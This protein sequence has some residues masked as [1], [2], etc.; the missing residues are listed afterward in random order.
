MHGVM[1]GLQRPGPVATILTKQP[2]PA[3][4]ERRAVMFFPQKRPPPLVRRRLLEYHELLGFA[5]F[6]PK[7][8]PV[9]RQQAAVDD[10]RPGRYLLGLFRLPGKAGPAQSSARASIGLISGE[11]D[12]RASPH[13]VVVA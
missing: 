12:A 5:R 6:K 13:S 2:R 10:Q 3:P 8:V 11:R 1:S 9:M 4:A 7:N